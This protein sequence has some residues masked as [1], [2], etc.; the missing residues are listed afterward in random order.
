MTT[1]QYIWESV[2]GGS[3]TITPYTVNPLLGHST[4]I[5]L[6]LKDDQLKYLEEE[7]IDDIFKKHSEFILYPI[8]LAVTK[9]VEKVR[10]NAINFIICLFTD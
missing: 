1:E 2:V 10:P 5:C 8:Q 7:K 6:Y 4:E 3:F 9:E